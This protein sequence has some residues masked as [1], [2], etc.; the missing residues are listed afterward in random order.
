MKGDNNKEKKMIYASE[1]Y[2]EKAYFEDL[3]KRG[4]KMHLIRIER[5]SAP[6]IKQ[7]N[8]YKVA[9]ACYKCNM[10]HHAY[11]TPKRALQDAWRATEE[12]EG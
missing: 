12:C 3:R 5:K 2:R 10:S 7:I 1:L 9:I 4:L 6:S 8:P 11:G